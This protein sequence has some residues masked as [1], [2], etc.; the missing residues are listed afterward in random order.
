MSQ[1]W[2]DTSGHGDWPGTWAKQG[3]LKVSSL[4]PL[5]LLKLADFRGRPPYYP[6]HGQGLHGRQRFQTRLCSSWIQLCLK[7]LPLVLSVLSQ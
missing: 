3:P 2:P 5:E 4:F 6:A 1:A 7:L